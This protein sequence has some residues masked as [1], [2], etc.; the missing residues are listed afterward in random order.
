MKNYNR[1]VTKLSRKAPAERCIWISITLWI[2]ISLPSVSA[3]ECSNDSVQSYVLTEFIK[4]SNVDTDSIKIEQS[5]FY[6]I[7]GKDVFVADVELTKNGKVV[8]FYVVCETGKIYP[9]QEPPF[10]EVTRIQKIDRELWQ[11]MQISSNG[12]KIDIV[13]W[14][15]LDDST[16]STT[17]S[18]LESIGV[19]D[20]V[21]HDLAAE[22]KTMIT[23]KATGNSI[24]RISEIDWVSAIGFNSKD[25]QL[26]GDYFGPSRFSPSFLVV[27][28]IL[29]FGVILV[30]TVI[31]YYRNKRR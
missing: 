15:K 19:Q 1:E 18:Q 14:K 10:S 8:P 25:Y 4:F 9:Y 17:K 29:I 6:Q 22:N 31:F 30:I 12:D 16:T 11:R 27:A 21:F 3:F 5:K 2:L 20:I 24:T 28:V 26:F 13:I 7:Y 23:A